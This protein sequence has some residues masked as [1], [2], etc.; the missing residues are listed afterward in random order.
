MIG[1]RSHSVNWGSQNG[2]IDG[3]SQSSLASANFSDHSSDF[4]F[5]WTAST[6]TAVL[7]IFDYAANGSLFSTW[8]KTIDGSNNGFTANN[9]FLYFGGTQ[10][11]TVTDFAVSTSA[12]PEPSSC[13]ALTAG[14]AL[15]AA[16][17]RRRRRAL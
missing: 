4:V 9:T 15:S 12:I 13:A 16:A 10:G 6:K 11:A 3:S 8:T 2:F 5:Q 7:T 14:F 1:F 17:L